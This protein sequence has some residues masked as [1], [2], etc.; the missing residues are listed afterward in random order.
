MVSSSFDTLDT[1]NV[2]H[3]DIF[4]TVITLIPLLHPFFP[5]FYSAWPLVAKLNYPFSS[6]IHFPHQPQLS[7]S[8]GPKVSHDFY[9]SLFFFFFPIKG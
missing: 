9:P 7:L 5:V 4:R 1:K 8:L 3:V 6:S 2:F